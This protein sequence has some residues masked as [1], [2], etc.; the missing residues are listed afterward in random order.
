MSATFPFALAGFTPA[1][2]EA[3]RREVAEAILRFGGKLYLSKFPYLEPGLFRQ[4]YP[5]QQAFREV[6]A[7]VDPEGVFWSEAAARLFA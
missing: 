7:R 6:K 5:A 1:T 4:M 3:F 2:L